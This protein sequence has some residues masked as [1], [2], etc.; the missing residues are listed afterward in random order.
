MEVNASVSYFMEFGGPLEDDLAKAMLRIRERPH[1]CGL[2]GGA[3]LAGDHVKL[4]I[5]KKE[6]DGMGFS[7]VGNFFGCGECTDNGRADVISVWRRMADKQRE[8]YRRYAHFIS[9]EDLARWYGYP[10][11]YHGY[12]KVDWPRAGLGGDA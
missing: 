7:G 12:G 1:A 9:D 4:Y 8:Y 10:G 5:Y 3:I 11:K 2:C 6:Y